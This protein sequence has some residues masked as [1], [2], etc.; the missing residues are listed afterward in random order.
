M[1]PQCR[2]IYSRA[3]KIELRGST[4]FSKLFAHL[5]C[6]YLY[7][8]SRTEVKLSYEKIV[9]EGVFSVCRVAPFNS[10]PIVNE[11]A[12]VLD[13]EKSASYRLH[14]TKNPTNPYGWANRLSYE[15]QR[16]IEDI[17]G[18][19]LFKKLVPENA[20]E[21][22]IGS[23]AIPQLAYNVKR[24]QYRP[25]SIRLITIGDY[26]SFLNELVQDGVENPHEILCVNAS[27]HTM[28]FL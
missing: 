5:L 1:W 12:M 27:F 20:V 2:G 14:G 11:R 23:A 21:L 17:A 4:N 22:A 19:R 25:V 13:R 18:K 8:E 16:L 26:C 10:Y 15:D 24:A 3:D 9:E 28:A 6:Q 7:L